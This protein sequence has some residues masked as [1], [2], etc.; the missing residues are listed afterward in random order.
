MDE[1]LK[2]LQQLLEKASQLETIQR[3]LSK[4]IEVLRGEIE[5]AQSRLSK[6][7]RPLAAETKPKEETPAPKPIPIPEKEPV[8]ATVTEPKAEL[9]QTPVTQP[10]KEPTPWEEFIGT[11][12]LNKIGIAILVIGIGFGVKYAI[13]H[14]LLNPLTRIILGYLAGAGLLFLAL[15]IKKDYGNFSAVLLSGGMASL[16][17]VTYA[18]YDFYALIPQVAA[19]I[20]MVLFTAFTVLAAHHYNL[21]VIALLGLTGAY[22]VPFLLSDGSGKALI[23]FSYIAIIN[24]GILVLSFLKGWKITHYTAF[25]LTWLIYISWYLLDYNSDNHFWIALSFALIY[26]IIFY[27]ALLANKVIKKE[28]FTIPDLA[29]LLIN[30]FIHYGIGYAVINSVNDGEQHLG[31]FTVFNALLHFVVCLVLYKRQEK[32]EHIF[33]FIAGLVLTFLS[34]A[35]PVQLEGN[36]VTLIWAAEAVLLFWI[37]RSKKIKAY[38]LMS[39]P[40]VVLAII[41]L[42]DDWDTFYQL[43]L[44]NPENNTYFTPFLNIHFFTGIWISIALYAIHWLNNYP[45]YE[46]PFKSKDLIMVITYGVPTLLLLALYCTFYIE[47]GYYWDSRMAQTTVTVTYE[48]TSYPELDY[49]LNSFKSLWRLNF[50]ALLGIILSIACLRYSKVEKTVV[51]TF[52]YNYVVIAAL[53]VTGLQ[54]LGELRYNYLNPRPSGYFETGIWYLLFRYVVFALTLPLLWFNHRFT[55]LDFVREDF[56]KMERIVFH[57]VILIVLSSELIHWLDF[58]RIYNT[59]KLGLSILWGI[60]ASFMIILGLREDQKFIRITAIIIFGITVLKLFVY[61]MAGMS[62]IGKTIVM[63]SLGVLMLISSFLYNRRKKVKG[64]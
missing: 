8:L 53:I 5:Q 42:T 59:D 50:S 14:D 43:N 41:S 1:P 55:Q 39:Y 10:K 24:S 34:I 15:R 9:K 62:T 37:G 49:T 18:A 51:P 60:Y 64:L 63:I 35:V 7:V 58:G 4:E 38:E 61:D 33:Y 48:T 56:K 3:N 28:P 36:W 13:D 11:N 29:F 6:P 12:L 47:I 25:A 45:G 17:F 21:Q 31:M 30:S 26:F 20:L 44:Y 2:Q 52:I 22:A 40:L 57:L 19:F 16:Y 23:L 27:S 54:E 46:A 32:T